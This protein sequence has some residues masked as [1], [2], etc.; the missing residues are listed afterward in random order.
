MAYMADSYTVP[1]LH[2]WNLRLETIMGALPTFRSFIVPDLLFKDQGIFLHPQ[3]NF[4]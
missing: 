2:I 1:D 4:E 3:K